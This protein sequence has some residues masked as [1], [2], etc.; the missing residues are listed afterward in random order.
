MYSANPD[1][2]TDNGAMIAWM[3]HELQRIEESVDIREFNVDAIP[4]IPLG[5]Y[6]SDLSKNDLRNSLK[7]KKEKRD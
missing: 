3:G 2:C 5:S 6:V 4:K 7:Y 1:L